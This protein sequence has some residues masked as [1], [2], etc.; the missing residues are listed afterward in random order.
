M[1]VFLLNNPSTRAK[2]YLSRHGFEVAVNVFIVGMS[3]SDAHWLFE[4]LTDLLASPP[5]GVL[6][7]SP[8]TVQPWFSYK[9]F[10][11]CGNLMRIIDGIPLKTVRD[12]K[13][14]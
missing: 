6:W 3:T 10:G 13:T 4:E 7:V 1:Q 12:K 9:G 11:N 14:L 5:S 8:S 2:G